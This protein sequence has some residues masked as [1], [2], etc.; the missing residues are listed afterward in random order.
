MVF[1]F[2][3]VGAIVTDDGGVCSHG[4]I[5]SREFGIPAVLGTKVATE[6]LRDGDGVEVDA[7]AGVVRILEY[8]DYKPEAD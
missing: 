8:G 3:Q 7:A 4:A 6:V 5:V 1:A 2:R